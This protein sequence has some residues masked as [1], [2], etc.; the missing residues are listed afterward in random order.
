[1]IIIP[2]PFE[3]LFLM[4]DTCTCRENI[5]LSSIIT[6]KNFV[7]V[8]RFKDISH[9]EMFTLFV[10]VEPYEKSQNVIYQC[11]MSI[12]W[13]LTKLIICLAQ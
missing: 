4:Y 12:Y 5:K 2:I 7:K 9:N 8:T 1:M 11:L 6:P 10:L 13:K 3:I